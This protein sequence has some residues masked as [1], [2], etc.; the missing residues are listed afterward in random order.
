LLPQQSH[1]AVKRR[2][3]RRVDVTGFSPRKIIHRKSYGS[4]STSFLEYGDKPRAMG[5]SHKRKLFSQSPEGVKQLHES[6]SVAG[7]D[8]S[9]PKKKFDYRAISACCRGERPR[10]WGYTFWYAS[11]E[12]VEEFEKQAA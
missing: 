7:R 10:H 5:C 1:N 11:D 12:E 4:A 6:S 8:L 2:Q 9:T 3:T